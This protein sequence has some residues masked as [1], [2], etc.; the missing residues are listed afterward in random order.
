MEFTIKVSA[1]LVA[2]LAVAA[3]IGSL[4]AGGADEAAVKKDLAALKGTW[5]IVS[6]ERDGKNVTDTG[7]ILT[8]DGIGKAAVKKGSQLLFAGAIKIDPTKKPKTL[9]A[10]QESD[11]D[12]KGKTLP[13]IYELDGD[14][15]KICS[16]KERPTQF[17]SAPGSSSFLRIYKR[18]K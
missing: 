13:G 4:V 7:V 6:A 12:L 16:G 5:I 1:L 15:L 11:G 18:A 10:T 3:Q 9:D 14:T 17:S 2:F 8:F